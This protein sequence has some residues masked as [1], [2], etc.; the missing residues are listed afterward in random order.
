MLVLQ[1]FL[2]FL[3]SFCGTHTLDYMGLIFLL[4]HFLTEEAIRRSD[5]LEN[6]GIQTLRLV[7]F[8]LI[9]CCGNSLEWVRIHLSYIHF[10]E[11]QVLT[12]WS[13]SLVEMVAFRPLATSSIVVLCQHVLIFLF[14]H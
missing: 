6:D 8:I 12:L 3:F 7:L 10:L 4:A 11:F 13:Y 5:A 9:E 2:S 14:K 1:L